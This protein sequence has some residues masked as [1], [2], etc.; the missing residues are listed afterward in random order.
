MDSVVISPLTPPANVTLTSAIELTAAGNAT[1]QVAN[2]GATLFGAVMDNSMYDIVNVVVSPSDRTTTVDVGPVTGQFA[3]RLFEEDFAQGA[4]VTVT[5][6]GASSSGNEVVAVPVSYTVTGVAPTDGATQALSRMAFGPTPA[7]YARLRGI[8]FEAYVEEQLN[9]ATIDDRGF[10]STRPLSLLKPTTR[11]S[12]QLLRSLTA[13]EIARASFSEK[14]LQE[15]MARFWM[16]H[17]HAVTKD[18]DMVQQNIDDREFYRQNALGNFGDM[19]LYSARSPLMSQYLDNDQNRR[20]RINENYGREIMELSTIGV[21]AG[22]GPDDVIAVSRIFTGW[23]YR[24]TNPDAEGVASEYVFEFFPDRHDEEDKTIPFFG[25]TITGRSGPAGIEEGEEF[26]ALL[27]QHP[28]TRTRI[29]GKIVQ[30][31]VADVPP[32]NLTQACA[33]SWE[34][35]G[36]EITPMLRAILLDPTFRQNVQYQRTKGKTPV[37]YAI[38]SIRAFGALPRGTTE[39]VERFYRDFSRVFE[40]AGMDP[41]EFPLP[42]GLPEEASAWANS[43]A[44]IASYRRMTGIT[45]DPERYGLDL[46]A[47]ITDAGLETAEEVASYLLTVATADRFSEE[48]YEAVLEALKGSDGIFEPRTQGNNEARALRRAMGLIVVTPSFQLQ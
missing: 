13:Y 32:A 38:G 37:E 22:Y 6:T 35:T 20:G 34:A 43:A 1:G 12:G 8:G 7:L 17:F 14:Q 36:G 5:L 10:E 39:E 41:L 4:E 21:E 19:L 16:N 26:V 27:A 31:L 24:R 47:Q 23:A 3:V 2:T 44:M 9:P 48:E 40:D 28:L 33:A 30:L 15:V 29:C 25:I 45:R 18:T 46:M 42:T 11:D